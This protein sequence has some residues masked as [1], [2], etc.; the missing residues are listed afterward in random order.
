ML[1]LLLLT[2]PTLAEAQSNYGRGEY[3]DFG[4]YSFDK[5]ALPPVQGLRRG[6]AAWRDPG[7]RAAQ[8][9][10]DATA[11]CAGLKD[12][13]Y[14]IDCL[15]ERLA[16]IAKA[17]PQQGPYAESRKAIEAA[18]KKLKAVAAKYADPSKP[19]NKY[20][21]GGRRPQTGTRPLTP[22]RP[23]AAAAANREAILIIAEAE[24]VLLRSSATEVAQSP[25]IQR[26]A[27][28]IGS[29]KVLLRST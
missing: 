20:A 24:T 7:P 5:D 11:F 13:A 12:E 6:T 22:I 19:R 9:L 26:I 14:R 23:E 10:T 25:Q 2:L 28:A 16:F 18:S 3:D 15:A 21:A 27:A 8:A 1:A 4:A 29:N 17:M